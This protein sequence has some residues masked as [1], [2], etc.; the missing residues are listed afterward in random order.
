MHRE[1]LPD[2]LG[3]IFILFRSMHNWT[4]GELAEA[5]GTAPSVISE[6]ENGTRRPSRRAIVRAAKAAGVPVE[7]IDQILPALRS[8]REI[9]RSPQTLA[10][11]R[12]LRGGGGKALP[13][14]WS[15]SP[16]PP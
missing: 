15:R 14:G 4:Q 16:T 13:G 11:G 5:M 6:Y 9:L 7:R 12:P 1:E 8:L 10:L 3:L 2:E